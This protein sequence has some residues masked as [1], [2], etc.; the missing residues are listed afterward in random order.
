VGMVGVGHLTAHTA[1]KSLRQMVF[2]ISDLVQF[3][4]TSDY[5]DI[6]A[7]SLAGQGFRAG[8]VGIIR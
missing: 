1:A 4:P 7:G 8:E 5:A 3:M 2:H 6:D